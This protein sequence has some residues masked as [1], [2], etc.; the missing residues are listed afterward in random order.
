MTSCLLPSTSPTRCWSRIPRLAASAGDHRFDDRLPDLSAE[1]VAGD[2]DMLRD[3]SAA[4]TQV[5]LDLLDPQE[6]VDHAV[7]LARVERM[8]FER[9]EI[10]EHEWNPLVHNPA[11]LLNALI[12]RPFAPAEERLVSLAARLSAI[13]DALAT[14]R[15]TLTDS[16]QSARGDRDRT[17][18]GTARLVRDELPA[19]LAEA[20]G[21]APRWCEPLQERAAASSTS[22]P[23]GCARRRRRPPSR[24]PR[25]GRR[26][27]EA[28]LWHT[29]DTE[30]GRR[31]V[32]QRAEAN[33]DAGHRA[34]P[35]G[36]GRA[37]RRPGDR[38]HGPRPRSTRLAADA[39][40]NDTIVDLAKV[41]LDEATAFVREHDLSP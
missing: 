15:A 39:P 16:P 23:A 21:A 38:R 7:L 41:T 2:I 28:R 33:L 18:A 34:A 37:D 30:L 11:T 40:D 10:R 32:L 26:L 24:D 13:P 14:A 9:T 12:S 8:L 22:S 1:A 27:W 6:Q 4:L 31:D 19:L 20:P 5:D 35:G 17:V 25:L 3:A 29:L 36:R